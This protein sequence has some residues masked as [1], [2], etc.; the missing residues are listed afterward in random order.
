MEWTNS[1]EAKTSVKRVFAS[2]K[3]SDENMLLLDKQLLKFLLVGIANTLVGCGLMFL[4]YYCFGISYWISSAC[5][6]LTGGILSYFLNKYFT[7]QNK[8]KSF[9]QIIYFIINIAICYFLAY[10]VA[11]KS[12]SFILSTQSEKFRDTVALLS[13]MCIFTALNY[14]GQRLIVFNHKENSTKNEALK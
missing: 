10:F 11:K 5:N 14:L 8:Q 13:G 3:K 6:Y 12:V 9:K 1:I 2:V 4:L 7:F